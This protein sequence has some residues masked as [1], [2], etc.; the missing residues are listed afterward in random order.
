M[1]RFLT[2]KVAVIAAILFGVLGTVFGGFGIASAATNSTTPPPARIGCVSSP[3]RVLTS[4]YENPPANFK[5]PTG[6]AVSL[7][8]SGTVGATGA[9]GPKGDTGAVGATGSS[10]L[11]G[12]YY[13]EAKYD[14]GDTNGGAVATVACKSHSDVAISGGV[15]TLAAGTNGLTGNV[16]VSSSFAGR[17]DWSTNTPIAGDL[18][19]WIVQFGGN[20]SST[21]LGDPHYED[22]YALCVPSTTIPVDVTYAESGS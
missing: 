20:S 12:A 21:S 11:A 5:C 10:G 17:M 14:V 8:A 7:S 13:A 15:Q 19:G 4:V 18:S 3:N 9:Q 2:R 16:P 22:I 6:F 1:T